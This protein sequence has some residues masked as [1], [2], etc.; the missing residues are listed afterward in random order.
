VAVSRRRHTQVATLLFFTDRYSAKDQLVGGSVVDVDVATHIIGSRVVAFDIR[1]RGLT[2]A[3]AEANAESGGF[4][5]QVIAQALD[6]EVDAVDISLENAAVE[7]DVAALETTPRACDVVRGNVAAFPPVDLVGYDSLADWLH[8][9]IVAWERAPA[10]VKLEAKCRARMADLVRRCATAVEAKT[11]KFLRRAGDPV[12]PDSRGP[13][14]GEAVRPAVVGVKWGHPGTIRYRDGTTY[15]PE[16]AEV[17]DCD[18]AL[19]RAADNG[20]SFRKLDGSAIGDVRRADVD[21]VLVPPNYNVTD[22]KSVRCDGSQRSP[23][24]NARYMEVHRFLWSTFVDALLDSG[25][26]LDN[27]AALRRQHAVC[28]LQDETRPPNPPGVTT[29]PTFNPWLVNRPPG[30]QEPPRRRGA[31]RAARGGGAT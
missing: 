14:D 1:V 12:G 10:N 28:R 25:T 4:M 29:G 17:V 9:E 30:W 18:V 19:K 11:G 15:Q 22:W 31:R 2:W 27:S 5:A 23:G 13:V 6:V 21:M 16:A 3:V 7:E 24:R 8:A 20:A 26:T